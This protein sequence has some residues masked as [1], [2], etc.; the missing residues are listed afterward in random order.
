MLIDEEADSEQEEE[1]GDGRDSDDIGDDLE[2]RHFS[3]QY[4]DDDQ[5]MMT[6][7]ADN[8][9]R[10]SRDN[11]NVQPGG[12][13]SEASAARK[14]IIH[15]PQPVFGHSNNASGGS[16]NNRHHLISV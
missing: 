7:S 9:S 16:V 6:L 8:Y 14:H 12:A 1:E 13:S 10:T 11:S 2:E 4:D 15:V 5:G 3:P